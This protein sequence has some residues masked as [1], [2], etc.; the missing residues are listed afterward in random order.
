M[1]HTPIASHFD[2]FG[3]YPFLCIHHVSHVI[4]WWLSANAAVWTWF[5]HQ[6]W[7]SMIAEAILFKLHPRVNSWFFTT[8]SHSHNLQNLAYRL[9]TICWTAIGARPTCAASPAQEIDEICPWTLWVLPKF[10]RLG[11]GGEKPLTQILVM[12]AGDCLWWIYGWPMIHCG[13]ICG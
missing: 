5:M 3:E 4:R 9:A 10:Q 8:H 12:V 11:L 7:S 6:S 13:L 2:T 1:I